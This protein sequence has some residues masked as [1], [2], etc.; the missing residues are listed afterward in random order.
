MELIWD[1]QLQYGFFPVD[2]E[3]TP[4][5]KE[6]WD[7]YKEYEKTDFGK[8]LNDFRINFVIEHIKYNTLCDIG[9]GCGQFLKELN[10]HYPNIG[11][12]GNDVNPQA[13]N[14][15]RGNKM[16]IDP[17]KHPRDVHT[18]FDSLEHIYRPDKYLNCK[19]A[20]I[21]IPIFKDRED[22][23]QSKHYRPTE[24]LWYFTHQGFIDW[25]KLLS[26][27]LKDWNDEE[28]KLGRESINTYYFHK[29]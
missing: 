7:K 23:L 19:Q 5:D 14:W 11:I 24:H 22:I 2:S 17:V 28:T 3:E 26:F 25:M 15:L 18:F 27:D 12:T 9:I 16:F 6:Y 20:F 13:I 4:Y 29:R 1:E 21:S 8:R 10:D